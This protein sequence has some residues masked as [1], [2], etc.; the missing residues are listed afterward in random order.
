VL[1]ALDRGK[2]VILGAEHAAG[3]VHFEEDNL[4]W[5]GVIKQVVG[6]RD[7]RYV[8]TFR[9]FFIQPF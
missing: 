2:G 7:L 6:Q 1:E 4:V 3:P 5:F 8:N 9:F